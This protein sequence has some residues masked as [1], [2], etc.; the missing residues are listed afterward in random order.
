[1]YEEWKQKFPHCKKS[2]LMAHGNNILPPV[3]RY[4][5]AQFTDE[6]GDYYQMREM[7]E[8]AQIFGLIFLS[9]Q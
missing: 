2:A 1:M 4:Y 5:S 9:K 6:D 7:S 8:A 3:G